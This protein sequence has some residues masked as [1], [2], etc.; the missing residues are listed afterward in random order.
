MTQS[1]RNFMGIMLIFTLIFTGCSSVS[2]VM[3]KRDLA[4]NTKMTKTIWLTPSNN[5]NVYVQVKNTTQY[6]VDVELG[7]KNKLLAKGYQIVVNPE[8]ADYWLQ[9]NVLKVEKMDLKEEGSQA[10]SG[11][12]GAGIGAGLGAYNTGSTNTAIAL[13]LI[14]GATGL[15]L[16]AI[17]EDTQYMM[18]TEVLVTETPTKVSKKEHSTQVYSIANKMN[19]KLEEAVPALESELERA[20]SNIF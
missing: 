2:T 14:G 8:K 1:I 12:A 16:D 20:I 15:A 9:V 10:L 17:T 4:T 7:I 19:L 5:K 13:G 6:D 18:V 11:L 3:K